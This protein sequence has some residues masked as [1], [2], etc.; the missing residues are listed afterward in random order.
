M[1]VGGAAKFFLNKQITF[2]NK[3]SNISRQVRV[4]VLVWLVA[5][6]LSYGI[7]ISLVEI[8]HMGPLVAKIISLICIFFISFILD[9]TITFKNTK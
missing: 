5:I 6:G 4:Y 2:L 3:T 7:M 8:L 1:V 9:K